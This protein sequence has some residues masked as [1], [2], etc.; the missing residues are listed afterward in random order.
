M[1]LA[2]EHAIGETDNHTLSNWLDTDWNSAI[3]V[4][5]FSRF[6]SI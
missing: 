3:W 6:A 2:L 1:F 4:D 5:C